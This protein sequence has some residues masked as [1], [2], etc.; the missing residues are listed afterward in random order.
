MP[1]PAADG[2]PRA[3]DQARQPRIAKP[4]DQR[5][6]DILDAATGL[7]RERG[8]DATT[9]QAIAASAGVAAGTVY[10]HFSSKEAVLAALHEDYEAGLLA[11][12]AQIAEGVVEEEV[13]TATTLSNPEIVGRFVDGIVEY[14]L[15]RRD[16]SDVIAGR[17]PA[18]ADLAVL[19]RGLD[20][21]LAA[22]IREGVRLGHVHASDPDTAARL[23]NLAAVGSISNAIA[24]DD[25]DALARTVQGVKELY[26]K[27]LAPLP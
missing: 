15:E 25:A 21:V 20:D 3:L 5:R 10:L 23:L 14:G 9:V 22:V 4:A 16:I 2:V 24:T 11:R 12:F 8:F 27:A 26:V 6:R 13:A 19:T 17:V 7:F 18:A 1:G